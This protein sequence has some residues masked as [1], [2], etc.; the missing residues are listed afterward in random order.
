M[1]SLGGASAQ[2]GLGAQRGALSGELSAEQIAVRRAHTAPAMERYK[3]EG[4]GRTYLLRVSGI[5][6]TSTDCLRPRDFSPREGDRG[7]TVGFLGKECDPCCL[8]FLGT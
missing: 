1:T 6:V 3:G 4:A 2:P 8:I 7:A 5:Q